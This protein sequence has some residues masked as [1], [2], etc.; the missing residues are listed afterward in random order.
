MS[1]NKSSVNTDVKHKDLKVNV[2][3]ADSMVHN[4]V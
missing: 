2:G 4:V 3:V 1:T